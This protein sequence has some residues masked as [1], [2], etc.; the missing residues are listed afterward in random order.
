[1]NV[2]IRFVYQPTVVASPL[3]VPVSQLLNVVL[4]NL[5]SCGLTRGSAKTGDIGKLRFTGGEAWK[6]ERVEQCRAAPSYG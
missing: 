4:H 2:R 6:E 5:Y 3:K 1:M